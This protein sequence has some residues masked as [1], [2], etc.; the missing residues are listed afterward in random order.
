MNLCLVE[1][2]DLLMNGNNYFYPSHPDFQYQRIGIKKVVKEEYPAFIPDNVAVAFEDLTWHQSRINLSILANIPGTITNNNVVEKTSVY[3]NFTLIKD[4]QLHLNLLPC[5]LDATIYHLLVTH[6][7]NVIMNVSTYISILDFSQLPLIN[8]RICPKHPTAADLSHKMMLKLQLE[9]HMKVLRY[10]KDIGKKDYYNPQTKVSKEEHKHYMAKE[11]QIK[12]AGC[13]TLPK[14]TD[15][16]NKSTICAQF[17]KEI[18]PNH[19]TDILYDNVKKQLRDI[20]GEI[21]RYK[22]YI[23]LCNQWLDDLDDKNTYT[24]NGKIGNVN[25]V[26]TKITF[27]IVE[28]KVEYD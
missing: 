27:N 6:Y 26:N 16:P 8:D 4:G 22:L 7:P 2:I 14:V 28:V 1:L 15:L 9:C 12:I 11:F 19:I 20:N 13:S 23:I 21:Q 5:Q 10:Y 18:D 3:R 17:M 25:I 24:Y